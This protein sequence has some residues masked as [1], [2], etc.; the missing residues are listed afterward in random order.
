[1]WTLYDMHL[2]KLLNSIVRFLFSHISYTEYCIK[3]Q[4]HSLSTFG[5][6]RTFDSNVFVL[7]L[8]KNPLEENEQR[9]NVVIGK[10]RALI[11]FDNVSA[12]SQQVNEFA[13]TT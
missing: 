1:M 11:G 8:I 3:N 9:N 7:R 4:A 13:S 2:N 6:L 5:S 10:K 12:K